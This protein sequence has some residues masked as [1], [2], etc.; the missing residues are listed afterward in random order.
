MP[1]FEQ[2]IFSYE[3]FG[4]CKSKCAVMVWIKPDL[5]INRCCVLMI[6]L[7]DNPGTS[8]TNASE[9]VATKLRRIKNLP[10]ATT[11]F[12]MYEYRPQS[13]DMVKYRYHANI[14]E[15]TSAIWIPFDTV[16][17]KEY[18]KTNFDVDFNEL[19]LQSLQS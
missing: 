12:E 10:I 11:F 3:G 7:D 14:D 13:V 18:L 4:R 9:I 6:E 17:F 1:L 15:F 8:I 5:V 2:F 19:S 16:K